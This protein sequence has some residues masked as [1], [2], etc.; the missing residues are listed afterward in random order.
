[1]KKVLTLVI[2]SLLNFV[3]ILFGNIILNDG[4]EHRILNEINEAILIEHNEFWDKTTSLIVQENGTINSQVI[5][6]DDS[7]FEMRDNAFVQDFV[8][9]NNS[10][11]NVYNGKLNFRLENNSSLSFW[12][13]QALSNIQIFNSSDFFMRGGI[14]NGHL[15]AYDSSDIFLYDGIFEGY[16]YST[17]YS[18]MS[19]YGGTF[20]EQ[21][22]A[23]FNSKIIIYGYNFKVDGWSAPYGVYDSSH[24][25]GTLTGVLSNGDLIN[26]SI[27]IRDDAKII[28]APIP[29]PA[30][31]LLLCVGG[32]IL[33]KTKVNFWKKEK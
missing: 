22:I 17:G 12:Q 28:L 4:Q 5:A 20:N 14:S 7:R 23:G 19:I 13:G 2:F 16:L 9:K 30:T 26:T 15:Y 18:E 27:N 31:F 25:E 8:G 10:I 11:S 1:M 21:I 32:L 3:N 29:E 24:G 6:Y 33:R